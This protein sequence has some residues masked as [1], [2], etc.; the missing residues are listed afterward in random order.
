MNPLINLVAEVHESITFSSTTKTNPPM[1]LSCNLSPRLLLYSGI[2]KIKTNFVS[3]FC[4]IF[5]LWLLTEAIAFW[6]C[7][8]PGHVSELWQ[9]SQMQKVSHDFFS[10]MLFSPAPTSLWGSVRLLCC[11]PRPPPRLLLSSTRAHWPTKLNP[12]RMKMEELN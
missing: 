11:G 9:F 1:S 10:S 5:F 2:N 4:R 3:L 6:I 12:L 7:P 8:S